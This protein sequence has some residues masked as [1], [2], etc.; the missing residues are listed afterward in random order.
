MG[1]CEDAAAAV[2]QADVFGDAKDPGA[3]ALRLAKLVEVVEDLE[4]GLLRDLFGILWTAADQPAVVKYLG[5]EVLDE[6]LEGIRLS[7]EQRASQVRLAL[8]IHAPIVT[9]LTQRQVRECAA[10]FR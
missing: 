1:G 4:Q 3:D 5:A 7:G 10:R 9:R 8:F 2:H 6:F